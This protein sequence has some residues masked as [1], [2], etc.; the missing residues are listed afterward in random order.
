MD[1]S[2]A[3]Q[4]VG[5]CRSTSV[6]VSLDDRFFFDVATGSNAPMVKTKIERKRVTKKAVTKTFLVKTGECTVYE[7]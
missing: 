3:W 4:C 5:V 2:F 1:D 7:L 6:G